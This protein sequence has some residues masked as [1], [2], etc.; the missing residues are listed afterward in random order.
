MS[1]N[2]YFVTP[3][4][5]GQNP[6]SFGGFRRT[7]GTTD[8][9]MLLEIYLP[10]ETVVPLHQHIHDQVGYIVHGRFELTVDGSTQILNPGD[11]Y[12]VPGNMPHSGRAVV[13]TVLVEIFSPPREEFRDPVAE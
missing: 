12:A 5:A 6:L 2:P 11:S 3:A 4:Q 13:D 10:R 1:N 9:M 7:M 8:H